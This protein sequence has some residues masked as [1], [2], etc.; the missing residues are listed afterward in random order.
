[1]RRVIGWAN[2]RAYDATMTTEHS[3]A[4]SVVVPSRIDH[5]CAQLEASAGSAAL[6]VPAT[7]G[8]VRVITHFLVRSVALVSRYRTHVLH[9]TRVDGRVAGRYGGP[10]KTAYRGLSK[11]FLRL[12][13]P[14]TAASPA[15]APSRHSPSLT[16]CKLER[17]G[18]NKAAAADREPYH[19][20]SLWLWLIS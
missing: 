9:W 13:P 6:V 1:M 3:A 14:W 10:P 15:T 4:A 20:A 2:A 18:D 16:S 19:L 12:R 7:A 8:R 17:R 11:E 5:L